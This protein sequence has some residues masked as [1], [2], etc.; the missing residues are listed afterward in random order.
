MGRPLNKRN[1]GN[2]TVKDG[3]QLT[4]MATIDGT[5]TPVPAWIVRQKTNNRYIVTDGTNTVLCELVKEFTD[6]NQFIVLAED[7]LA[8]TFPVRSLHAHRVKTFDVQDKAWSY[9]SATVD[10]FKITGN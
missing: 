3:N 5:I 6:V 4:V 9:E 8:A 1:F 7:E 2:P 10:R